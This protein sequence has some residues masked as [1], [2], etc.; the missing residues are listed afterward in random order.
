MFPSFLT[1]AAFRASLP[2]VPPRVGWGAHPAAAPIGR[3]AALAS[4]LLA[5]GAWVGAQGLS[6][7][8]EL[9]AGDAEALD[10]FGWSVALNG[11]GTRALIGSV[12]D[13]DGGSGS[14]SAY[15]FVQNAGSWSLE[16]KLVALDAEANDFFGQSVAINLPGDRAVVG[17]IFDDDGAFNAGAA[18]VFARSGSTWIQ[19]AKLIASDPE[20]SDSFGKTVAIDWAGNRVVIGAD[21]KNSNGQ[22]SGAVYVFSRSGTTWSEEQRI[23]PADNQA[24]DAFGSSVGF[25][26]GGTRLVASADNDNQGA[27]NAGSAYIF[28]RSG[29]L[30]SQEA[31]LVPPQLAAS[32]FF[33]EDVALSALGDRLVV[34]AQGTDDN[35][36]N[37]GAAYLFERTGAAWTQVARLI[38]SDG[39]SND[40]F[41]GA[42]AIDGTGDAVLVGARGHDAAGP[43]VGAAYVYV[44]TGAGWQ[45]A[46]KRLPPVST[47]GDAYG[48]SL[49]LNTTGIVGVVG[50]SGSNTAATDAG[51]VWALASDALEVP[52]EFASIQAAIDSALPDD[53]VLVGPGIWSENLDFG[54]RSVVVRATDGA[55]ATTIAGIGGTVVQMRNGEGAST[56]LDGFTISGGDG[57]FG[58]GLRIAAATPTVRNCIFESNANATRGGGLEVDQGGGGRIEDCLFTQ[59][60]AGLGG[61][62]SVGPNCTPLFER[63]TFESNQSIQGGGAVLCASNSAPT[64]AACVFEHNTTLSRG[65][66]IYVAAQ[67]APTFVSCLLAQN[68]AVEGGGIYALTASTPNLVNVTLA[69]NSATN[70]GGLFSINSLAALSNAVVWGNSDAS[71]TGAGAQIEQSVGVGVTVER[72]IVEGGFASGSFVLDVDPRFADAAGGDYRLVFGSP[73]IDAGDNTLVPPAFEEALGGFERFLD[74][75]TTP[76]TGVGGAPVVDLGAYEWPDPCGPDGQ[77]IVYCTAKPNSLGCL[78]AIAASGTASATDPDPFTITASMQ[79][80]FKNGLL[81]YGLT[82]RAAIPFLGGTLC[83]A[84]PLRR[85]NLQ[86]AGGTAPPANDC[87]GTFSFDFNQWFQAGSDPLVQVGQVLRAQYWSRDPQNADGSGSALS[88]GLE[89]YVCP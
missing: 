5:L 50:A 28:T 82:G 84:P 41:G 13:D 60:A 69:Q 14:G 71:G 10:Q 4:A 63:C 72:G 64:F 58:A 25:D 75:P 67:A 29:T 2:S 51:A 9:T 44:R 22:N 66:A 87:S 62:V 83:V 77:S 32:D 57:D 7:Q 68:S 36:Q 73:G 30:W 80:N 16:S 24:G 18:Y 86:N 43:D 31:K 76:D 27:F 54:G 35:G 1:P 52:A 59:N 33:G 8:T 3:C 26:S 70:G 23:V 40:F 88:N 61:A 45:P 53:T 48:A 74:D 89:F 79:L 78:S 21:R 6:V 39:L 81:F 65:G 12:G 42:V 20:A 46:G 17:A 38:P 19:E 37:S 47:S 49:A 56:V 34:G 15:V 55:A 11:N 85:T